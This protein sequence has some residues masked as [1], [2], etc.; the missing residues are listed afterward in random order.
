MGVL[1]SSRIREG[2][3]KAGHRLAPMVRVQQK[4][5]RQNHRCSRG[6]PAFP[7]RLVLTAYS[8]LSPG[9]GLSCPRRS[10]GSLC[11][12]ELSASVGAPGPHGLAVRARVSRLLPHP[13]PPHPASTFVTTRTPLFDEAG[14]LDEATDLG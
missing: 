9:T 12:R 10:Q 5:T 1:L 13:R 8:E 14:Q 4:S 3:G 11:L 6:Y 7:A 2:A